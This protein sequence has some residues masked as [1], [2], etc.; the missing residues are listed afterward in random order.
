[1]SIN[2]VEEQHTTESSYV[3]VI[4]V[5]TSPG[6]EF[7]DCRVLGDITLIKV[8][9]RRTYVKPCAR[10]V[11]VVEE[12]EITRIALELE[13]EPCGERPVTRPEIEILARKPLKNVEI[14]VGGKTLF[15]PCH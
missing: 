5:D 2:P 8:A 15:A 9:L 7:V 3:E 11:D 1:M 10:V 4:R 6:G 13:A 14:R 12:G